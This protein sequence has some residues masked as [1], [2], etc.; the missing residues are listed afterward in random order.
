MVR[1]VSDDSD[2]PPRKTAHVVRTDRK[3]IAPRAGSVGPA[4]FDER[5][6]RFDELAGW[7][8]Q[9]DAGELL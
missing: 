5:W 4:A 9:L 3:P 6:L 8:S 2:R 7:R 1:I